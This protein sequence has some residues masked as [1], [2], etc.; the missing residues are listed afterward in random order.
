[1]PEVPPLP[2]PALGAL[3]PPELELATV[4]DELLEED[5]E[6]G[7]E[8][9]PLVDALEPLLDVVPVAPVTPV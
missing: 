5:V 9:T 6:E 1:M 2:V 8:E 7:T 3:A 4:P